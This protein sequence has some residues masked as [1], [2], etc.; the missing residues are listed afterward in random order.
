VA[1]YH[2]KH[3]SDTWHWCSNCSNYPTSDYSTAPSK[4]SSGELCNE[5]IGKQKAGNCS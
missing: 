3:G 5:C 4:P 2:K 1:G